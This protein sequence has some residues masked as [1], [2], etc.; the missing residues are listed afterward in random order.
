M[1]SPE[2]IYLVQDMALLNLS[3]NVTLEE[4]KWKFQK[5]L[6]KP[7]IDR[8]ILIAELQQQAKECNFSVNVEEILA[9]AEA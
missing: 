6:S 1:L 9:R 4:I 3:G 8:K 5:I 2:K 7:T